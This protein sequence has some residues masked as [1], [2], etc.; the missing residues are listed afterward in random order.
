MVEGFGSSNMQN[1][2]ILMCFR[3]H[4]PVNL[5]D[6]GRDTTQPVRRSNRGALHAVRGEH[7]L[8]QSLMRTALVAAVLSVTLS[9]CGTFC[10]AAGGSGGGFGGGCSTGVRF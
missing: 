9:G 1:Q 3:L 7:A 10:G 6:F 5:A 4:I 2:N 8:R